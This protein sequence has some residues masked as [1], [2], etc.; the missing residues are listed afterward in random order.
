[1]TQNPIFCL[2]YRVATWVEL[3]LLT[4][5]S[6]RRIFQLVYGRLRV[7]DESPFQLSMN[8]GLISG[9]V[10]IADLGSPVF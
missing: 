3:N 1:M 10:G 7:G 6:D 2:P 4:I 8:D 9:L 5:N